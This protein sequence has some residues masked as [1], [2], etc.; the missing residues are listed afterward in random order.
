MKYS[1]FKAQQSGVYKGKK[2]LGE[3]V[4][5]EIVKN[6]QIKIVDGL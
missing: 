5:Y 6:Q 2:E 1:G 3:Y 4:N